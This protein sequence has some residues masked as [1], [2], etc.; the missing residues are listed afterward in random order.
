MSNKLISLTLVLVVMLISSSSSRVV[1]AINE[2]ISSM[3]NRDI[4]TESAMIKA[5]YLTS[6]DA[7]VIYVP[8]FNYMNPMEKT[9][10]QL[11]K[12]LSSGGQQVWQE[13][14]DL[15]PTYSIQSINSDWSLLGYDVLSYP[16]T[17]IRL[18]WRSF[19]TYTKTPILTMEGDTCTLAVGHRLYQDVVIPDLSYN[20]GSR[21]KIRGDYCPL[22]PKPLDKA[23]GGIEGVNTTYVVPAAFR[24]EFCFFSAM[25]PSTEE[26][27]STLDSE[28]L[29][30]EEDGVWLLLN[31]QVPQVQSSISFWEFVSARG[32]LG[33]KS[34]DRQTLIELTETGLF[35]ASSG[36]D[37]SIVSPPISLDAR[38]VD[39]VV[40]VLRTEV[41]STVELFWTTLDNPHFDQRMSKALRLYSD[42]LWHTYIFDL[43]TEEGWSGVITGLRLDPIDTSDSVWLSSIS[44]R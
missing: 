25:V 16:E 24:G 40:I 37:A 35:V 43:S 29:A 20:E 10:P 4:I 12:D 2:N 23:L 27:N 21:E 34:A 19:S 5:R 13:I 15:S 8:H 18:Y 26:F 42:G 38:R 14:V 39:K 1:G 7:M 31:S 41:G 3:C 44:I 6:I 9:L 36:I 11:A 22:H 28:I 30:I 33:W 17:T 32:T